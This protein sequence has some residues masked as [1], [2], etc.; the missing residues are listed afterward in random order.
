TPPKLIFVTPSHQYPLGS[1]LSL[2]RRKQ[3]IAI[4]RQHKSWIVED[5]Y[6]S[7]FR[8]SGQPFPSLQGLEPDAPVIYM[9][10][11]SKTI[12]PALR[13]GYLVVPKKL[14]SPLRIV[15]SELYRGGHLLDQKVL[16]EFIREGH[17]EAHI[18]R[19]R[20]LYSKRHA[21]LID[22]ITR[23]L[24][25]DFLHEYNTAAGLHL[26][27]KLPS[28]MDDVLIASNAL[29]QGV[30]VR[31]LSQYYTKHY[32]TRQKGLLLG[33]ACVREQE[34]LVAFGVLLKCLRN[35]GVR[36]LS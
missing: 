30:K 27:L 29:D 35:A 25:A 13:I 20:L 3:L 32:S 18:R 36:T 17:Y 14:F 12:Y 26:I 23:H 24:G 2:E 34:I 10:T 6:D 5:D 8:F 28:N 33:F 4:A 7:E 9:G 15:A 31:A 1:H 16:A 19:M 22:L 11:F 21:F